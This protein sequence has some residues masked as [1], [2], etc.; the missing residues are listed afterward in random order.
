M[1]K[2]INILFI[3]DLVG[4]LGRVVVKKTL[5]AI[6]TKYSIDMVI[7]NGENS[8][9]GYGITDKVCT[10]MTAMGVD[11]ITMGNHVFDKKD[12]ARIIDACPTTI[13]PANYPPNVPGRDKIIVNVKGVKVAVLNLLGRVF[14]LPVDCPFRVAETVVNELKKETPIIIADFHAEATSEK[15]AFGYFMDGSVSAV[16]GTHTHVMTADEQILRGGTA[17]ITD[18]GMTGAY[19]SVIGMR[20]GEIITK[21]LTQM[22]SHFEP[23]TEG[24]GMINAVVIAINIETGKATSIKRINETVDMSTEDAS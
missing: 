11:V 16:L 22:P 7:A 1:A 10:E 4:R 3:G 17:Y 5:P 15:Y 20:K 24:L 23:E 12:F 21:F 6:K 19:D 18:V 8:A 9:G 14:M 2:D 13:R